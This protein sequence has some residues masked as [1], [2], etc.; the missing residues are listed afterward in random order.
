MNEF[1]NQGWRAAYNDE[2]TSSNPYEFQSVASWDWISGYTDAI[3]T[4]IRDGEMNV[5]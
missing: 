3:N 5:E 1:Y 4:Q 2:D